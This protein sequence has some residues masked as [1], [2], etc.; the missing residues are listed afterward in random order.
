MSFPSLGDLPDPRIEPRSPA[1]QADSLHSEPLG[2]SL[3]NSV[4][5]F[6]VVK[7]VKSQ[8]NIKNLVFGTK[9]L[10]S[11]LKQLSVS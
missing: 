7:V 6:K 2:K 3:R 8:E 10:Y 5:I 4:L 9:S 11:V 1:F